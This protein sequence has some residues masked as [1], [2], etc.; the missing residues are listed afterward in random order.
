MLTIT[1]LTVLQK[2]LLKSTLE[3][4]H[5]IGDKGSKINWNLSYGNV[6]ND[7]PDQRKVSYTRNTG[8]ND[9]YQA[10]VTTLGKENAT[11]FAKMKRHS[12]QVP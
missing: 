12:I 5:P 8:S 7:Q 10:N 6:L 3:G 2:A 1:R 11:L 4:N 9:P